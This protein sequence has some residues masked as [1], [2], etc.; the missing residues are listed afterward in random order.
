M[1]NTRM[2]HER[3]KRYNKKMIY[4]ERLKVKYNILYIGIN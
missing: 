3:Y 1:K 2:I 4:K